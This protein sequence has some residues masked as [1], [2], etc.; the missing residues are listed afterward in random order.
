M[1]ASKD[2]LVKSVMLFLVAWV[3]TAAS[4]VAINYMLKG[5]MDGEAI[6]GVVLAFLAF[7]LLFAA[8]QLP[9][10]FFLRRWKKKK[11]TGRWYVLA[12]IVCVTVPAL[13]VEIIRGGNW[14][15]TPGSALLGWAVSSAI[16]G[17]VVGTGFY[18]GYD[19][20]ADR[21]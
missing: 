18:R 14:A 2:Y 1:K 7:A 21:H 9:L 17:L 19:C 3:P 15:A 6:L 11:L 4:L 10:L 13:V 5:G 16:F 12:A 8:A 20:G